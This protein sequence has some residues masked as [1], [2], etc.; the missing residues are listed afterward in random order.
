MIFKE[1]KSI[2]F[3]PSGR[4][5][6]YLFPSIVQGC[7]GNC[8]YCVNQGTLISI[9]DGYK[10]VEEIEVGDEVISFSLEALQFE[11]NV[12]LGLS[13]RETDELYEIS[14]DQGSIFVTGEHPFYTK[15]RGWVE[16]E[17]LTLDDELLYDNRGLKV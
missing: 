9:P 1:L 3:H 7:V 5:S 6:D 16:A 8:T 4:S 12:V 11:N 14:T 10:K 13:Q 15:N 2:K 17:F